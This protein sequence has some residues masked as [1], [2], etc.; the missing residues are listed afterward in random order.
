MNAAP[1]TVPDFSE[2]LD[3]R[4]M[5]EYLDLFAARYPFLSVTSAGTSLYGR[6]IPMLRLG[7]EKCGRTVLYV[8][9]HHSMERLTSSLLLRFVCELC[10]AFQNGN[11][12]CSL[13]IRNLLRTRLLCIVPMLNV[14]GVDIH[15]YGTA[16]SPIPEQ[17]LRMNG[18]SD[19]FTHWQA[20]GRG[21]DLNHNYD[22]GFAEYKKIEAEAGITGGA[23]TR[24]SGEA[25]ESEPE[26]G[27]LA[28]YLR[29]DDSVKMILTLHTQGEEIFCGGR[30]TPEKTRQ[31]GQMLAQLSGYTL[32]APEGMAAYGGLTDWAIKK[33]AV[34]SFTVECGKGKNPLPPSDIPFIYEKIR[35][36]LFT[37]P[38]LI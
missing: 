23:P 1:N 2:P 31:I 33:L 11:R 38:I 7:N 14:D 19:D 25:P 22:C 29:F 34:P 8:G 35:K 32:A 4:R 3:Y 37:A 16:A 9:T 18:G 10:E 21:V 36:M 30:D 15:L 17:L 12:I 13:S 28:N 27:M 6:R 20:N 26:V 24:F 5:T